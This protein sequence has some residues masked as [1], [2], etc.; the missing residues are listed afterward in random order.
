MTEPQQRS[1]DGEFLKRSEN[2]LKTGSDPAQKTGIFT[3]EVFELMLESLGFARNPQF[4]V[5][6]RRCHI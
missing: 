3:S 5:D 4:S 1:R 6:L 2:F